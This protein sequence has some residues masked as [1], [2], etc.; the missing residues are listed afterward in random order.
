MSAY[1][2]EMPLVRY[3]RGGV[4][5]RIYWT[6]VSTPYLSRDLEL[7][8]CIADDVGKIW[9]VRVASLEPLTDLAHEM[10]SLSAGS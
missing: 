5:R 3:R 4:V 9:S 10:L 6:V 7:S 1:D 2:E 8:V